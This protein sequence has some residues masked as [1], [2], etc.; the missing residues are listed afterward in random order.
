MELRARNNVESRVWPKNFDRLNLAT[1]PWWPA[2][3]DAQVTF[4]QKTKTGQFAMIMN[5]ECGAL[6]GIGSKK[7]CFW[8][9]LGDAPPRLPVELRPAGVRLGDAPPQLPVELRPAGVRLGDA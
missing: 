4:P 1:S 8:L 5:P 3:R 7:A 6:R 9:P 2:C